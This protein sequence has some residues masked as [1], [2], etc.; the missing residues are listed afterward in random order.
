VSRSRNM[1]SGTTDILFKEALR[2]IRKSSGLRA[3]T[4]QK[5]NWARRFREALDKRTTARLE[6]VEIACP[7]RSC[8]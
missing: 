4:S 7:P 8:E 1:A 6:R 5:V 3:E 2:L